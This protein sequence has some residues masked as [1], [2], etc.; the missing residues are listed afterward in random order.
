MHDSSSE[1]DIGTT[2]HSR[3]MG[4]Q[5]PLGLMKDVLSQFYIK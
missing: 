5:V 1:D 3:Q 2:K 4:K